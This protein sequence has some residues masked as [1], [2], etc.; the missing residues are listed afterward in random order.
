MQ[1]V[2]ITGLAFSKHELYCKPA[3]VFWSG[4]FLTGI[5]LSGNRQTDRQ[6]ESLNHENDQKPENPLKRTESTCLESSREWLSSTPR[7]NPLKPSTPDPSK[8]SNDANEESPTW[9]SDVR[10]W[11]CRWC[12]KMHQD[13]VAQERFSQSTMMQ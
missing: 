1:T 7:G 11:K 6:T 8:K 5:L 10:E 13:S 12:E 4:S 2:I 9:T 3:Q